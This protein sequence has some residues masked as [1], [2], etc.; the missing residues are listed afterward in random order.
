ML[1]GVTAPTTWHCLD[2]S[3]E[4]MRPYGRTGTRFMCDQVYL[5]D[6]CSPWDVSGA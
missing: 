3:G 1:T 5:S 2:I 6:L 4:L